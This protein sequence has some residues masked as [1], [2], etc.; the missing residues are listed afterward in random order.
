[1]GGGLHSI[2]GMNGG[3][4]GL[5]LSHIP[6]YHH[7]SASSASPAA[8]SLYDVGMGMGSS[9]GGLG[10]RRASMPAALSMGGMGVN[11]IHTHS[12]HPYPQNSNSHN[13]QMYH[14][15]S[16]GSTSHLHSLHSSPSSDYLRGQSQLGLSRSSGYASSG[17]DIYSHRNSLP[18]SHSH[19]PTHQTQPP[20][21]AYVLSPV[22]Y[23]SS[24]NGSTGNRLP[25]LAPLSAARAY[26]FPENSGASEV[27]SAG[28]T[29]SQ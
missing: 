1:M 4:G 10:G 23:N 12:H 5:A 9:L 15:G 27:G 14:S 11:D 6:S 17:S 26:S 25:A 8:S 29:G 2:S 20:N 3:T 28:E 13:L 18:Y 24:S 21:P 19:Q 7:H 22:A 16:S